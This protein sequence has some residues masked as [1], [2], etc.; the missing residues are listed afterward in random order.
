MAWC[1]KWKF[2][3]KYK[4]KQYLYHQWNKDKALTHNNNIIYFP[5]K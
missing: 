5:N 4:F 1:Y 3:Y 2:F